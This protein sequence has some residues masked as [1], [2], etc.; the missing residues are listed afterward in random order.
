MRDEAVDEKD[1]F[2]STGWYEPFMSRLDECYSSQY[3][4]FW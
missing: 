2:W 4:R 3:V 1:G